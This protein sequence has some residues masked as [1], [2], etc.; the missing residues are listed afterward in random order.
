[1]EKSFEVGDGGLGDG[2]RHEMRNPL[3]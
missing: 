2:E 3:E 1:L